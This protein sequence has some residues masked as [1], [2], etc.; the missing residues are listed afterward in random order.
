MAQAAMVEMQIKEG[1]TLLEYEKGTRLV[2]SATARGKSLLC[3]W[4]LPLAGDW[5][6][7][8]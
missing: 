5:T 6:E 2:D 1:Q 8:G 3:L 4:A 7:L